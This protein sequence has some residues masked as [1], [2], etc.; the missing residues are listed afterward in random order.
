M[1]AARARKVAN[2]VNDI[3]DQEVFGE[4]ARRLLLVSWGGTFGAVRAAVER[5]RREGRDVAHMHLRWLNP[6]PRNVGELLKRFERVLVCELNMG[7]LEFVL[8]GRYLV[9]AEGLHKVRGRP[10][11]ISEVRAKIEEILG[12]KPSCPPASVSR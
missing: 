9:D 3:P 11:L 8:R 10:F 1:T 7:Q 2:V 5:A 4:D 6:M 12:G